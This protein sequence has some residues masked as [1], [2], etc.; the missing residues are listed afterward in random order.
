MSGKR[1]QRK[2]NPNANPETQEHKEEP[3]QEEVK[4]EPKEEAKEEPKKEEIEEPKKEEKKEEPKQKKSKKN[5]KEDEPKAEEPETDKKDNKKDN[6]KKVQ[7]APKYDRPGLENVMKRRFFVVPAFEIYNG[8]AGLYDYGPTGCALKNHIEQ[9]WREHF[10]LEE[11]LL[12]ISAT[13]L[14]PEIV[15]K[16]SGHVQKFTDFAVKDVKTQ[17]CYRCDKLIQEWINKEKKKKKITPEKLQELDNLYQDCENFEEKEIDECIQKYN[18]K[19]IDTG[20]DLSAAYKF[21][22]MFDT[23]I[24]PSGGLK[25]Y[26]RPETAQGHF[27]NFRHL[28]EFNS[29][30]IPF[31]SASIGLGFRNEIAPRSGLLRVREFTMA[32]IE[33]FVDP[34]NKKHKKYHLI[35][36]MK[37]PLW[38]AKT[39]ADHGP[40]ENNMTLEEAVNSG[41]INNE[42]LAYYIAKT[43]MF[44]T[45]IGIRTD[46]VRFRQHTPKE[47]AHYA[48]DCWD[49]EVETSYG[50]IEVAG[51]AD[52]ACYDLSHHAK[53]S[54]TE[55]V[56]ARP[57]KE[58]KTIKGVKVFPNKG[59]IFKSFKD[60]E[61]AKRLVEKLDKLTEEEKEEYLKEYEAEGKITIKLED[62]E[63][64]LTKDSNEI[65]IERFEQKVMEEKFIPSVIEP[66][67]G[68]GRIVYCVM[69]HCFKVRENDTKR[70]YFDFPPTVAPYKVS[71]LPLIAN[72]ELLKFVEP[73]RKTLVL[74]GVSYKIDETNDSIGRRYARTDEIGV[75]FGITIDQ[76]T[77]K[78]STVTLREID[79]MKQVRVPIDDVGVIIKNCCN[80]IEKWENIVQKYPAFEAGK[81]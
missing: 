25:G 78:D 11:N 64:T 42:T 6:K 68:I 66:S 80:R 65:K 16:T 26:L 31:G 58:A 20:N 18:I 32:E 12:E 49:A 70:T 37:L 30:R 5:K 36:D 52:R 62:A 39:Q 43:Y 4:E 22:L 8:V 44:L 21:N 13:C 81:K 75:P 53:V 74:N 1:K 35:K 33:Y 24:G 3:K 19:A 72:E 14:T 15:L 27:V 47:M 63:H 40:V 7:E 51:H 55:L 2:K 38:S 67:F 48:S 45:G 50:W 23:M 69:E 59:A 10:I 29:G 9:Y 46:G 73:I 61:Q 54:G 71:I 77:V 17:Q 41:I 79:T 76:D 34:L 57:L 60:K 56:A 28:C